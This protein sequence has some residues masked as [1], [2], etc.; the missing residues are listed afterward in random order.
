MITPG[1][2]A[3]DT[4]EALQTDPKPKIRETLPEGWGMREY[5]NNP[6][7]YYFFNASLRLEIRNPPQSDDGQVEIRR[8]MGV[9]G[10]GGSNG[11]S[12]GADSGAGAGG[13]ADPAVQVCVLCLKKL[14]DIRLFHYYFG[15]RIDCND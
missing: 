6:G 13:S 1:G 7:H 4:E 9:S 8:K 12:A 11:N 10:T 2:T 3:H 5:S 14:S 15:M